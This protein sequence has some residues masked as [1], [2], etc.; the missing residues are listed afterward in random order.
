MSLA[1][2]SLI[3][4]DFVWLRVIWVVLN[5]LLKRGNMQRLHRERIIFNSQLG[6]Y[7]TSLLISNLLGA[8]A[9]MMNITW[10]KDNG[11]MLG[12]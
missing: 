7:V 5:T 6:A 8:I 9:F 4:I 10:I 2:I 3:A 12:E 1:I 11:V